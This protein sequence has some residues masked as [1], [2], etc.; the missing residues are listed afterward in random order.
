MFLLIFNTRRT[1]P[2][3]TSPSTTQGSRTEV[4]VSLFQLRKAAGPVRQESKSFWT[5]VCEESCQG[6]M[7]LRTMSAVV[8]GR[9]EE[10]L[11]AASATMGAR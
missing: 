2:R 8:R 1:A 7:S 6:E 5:G 3:I 4:C 10:I 11:M 9:N